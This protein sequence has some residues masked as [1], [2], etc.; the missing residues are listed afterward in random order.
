MPLF[1]LYCEQKIPANIETVWEF[2]SS[3]AN[4]QKITPKYMGFEVLTPNLPKTMYPGMIIAY[5]VSPIPFL[6]MEWVTE[7]TH[8][9]EHHYFVDEQRSG[10]YKMWHHEHHVSPIE[11]GVLMTDRISYIPPFGILGTL[12]NALFIRRQIESI[13]SYRESAL[14][15]IFGKWV[16]S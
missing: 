16:L 7:I 3:P 9:K 14:E 15:S 5:R 1:Q 11:G 6:R 8:V 13:F 4:L 10:P 2:A 12:G